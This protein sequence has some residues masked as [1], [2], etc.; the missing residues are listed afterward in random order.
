MKFGQGKTMQLIRTTKRPIRQK[1]LAVNTAIL[2]VTG[3]AGNGS[4]IAADIYLDGAPYGYQLTFDVK[5][6]VRLR[7]W[8]DAHLKN[9]R[10]IWG[11]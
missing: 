11:Q 4:P 1:I 8:L 2:G 10:L 6:A 9:D 7:N 3:N 5:E